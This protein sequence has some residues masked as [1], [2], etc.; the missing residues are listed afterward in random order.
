MLLVHDERMQDKENMWYLDNKVSN[1]MCGY[2]D[3][4]M[5]LDEVIRGNVIFVNHS[6]VVIKWKRTNLIKLKD[7]SFQFSGDAYYI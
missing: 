4:L 5:E 6:K 2:K 3:K 7:I 1:H